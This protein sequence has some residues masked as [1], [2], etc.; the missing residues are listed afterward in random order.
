MRVIIAN[1]TVL[2]L[3]ATV[4][5]CDQSAAAADGA[6]AR[7]GQIAANQI[8]HRR[9][10]LWRQTVSDGGPVPHPA[11][12]L[13]VDDASEALLSPFPRPQQTNM[14]CPPP[15]MKR[16]VDGAISFSHSC[17]PPGGGKITTTGVLRGDLNSSFTVKTDT[18]VSGSPN[19]QM[20]GERRTTVSAV[21]IGSCP[22]GARGG[23]ITM[24][25]GI[26]RNIL[27]DMARARAGR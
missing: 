12:T 5:A 25:D 23:D 14:A 3:V 1:L 10:G 19:A 15:E 21:W 18:V 24:P 11:I 20:N 2:A 7:A 22:P 13:C 4:T 17:V 9:L 16:G 27:D 6:V 26:T 8:P